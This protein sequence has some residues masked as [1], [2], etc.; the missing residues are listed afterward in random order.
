MF[1]IV[2]RLSLGLILI[3]LTSGALLISDLGNRKGYSANHS[4]GKK[5]KITLIE[6]N[7]AAEVEETEHGVRAGLK[8]SGLVEGRDYDIAILNAQGDMATVTSLVDAAITNGADMLI[9][10][11]SPTLQAAVKRSQGRPVI[12]S[13]IAS[14]VATGAGKSDTD[15][16]PN[17]TGVYMQT[18]YEEVVKLVRECLPT[19]H[20]VATLF[21]P[22]EVNMVFHKDK[23]LEAATK[24][25]I[26]VITVPVNSTGEVSDAALAMCSRK[27]DAICQL[28]GNLVAASFAPIASA[29]RKAKLPVFAFSSPQSKTGASV[30]LSRDYMDVGRESGLV[31]ARVMRGENPAN[32][33][34]KPSEKTRLI[35]NLE[36]A[37]ASGLNVPQS[38]INR[39]DEVIGK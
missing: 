15:H 21:A 3:A 36:A 26:E 2:R 7:N 37:R 32:I 20:T 35:V 16:L 11:S 5:W 9:A 27:V 13:Y 10:L 8:E 31:A 12:F 4:A 33:P 18:K 39:A 25:N 38:I 17:I 28:P 29:A 23:L 14:P 1:L 24:Q 6:Y 22:T 19:A 30:V 34:F